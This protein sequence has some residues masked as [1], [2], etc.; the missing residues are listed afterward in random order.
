MGGNLDRTNVFDLT[1]EAMQ[2]PQIDFDLLSTDAEDRQHQTIERALAKVLEPIGV[3]FKFSIKRHHISPE[4]EEFDVAKT[5]LQ[6]PS[7]L[8]APLE[9]RLWVVCFSGKSLDCQVLAEPLTKALRKLNLEGFQDAVIQFSRSG[10]QTADW[11]LRIDLT[12]PTLI[13]QRWARWGDVQAITRLLNSR[14]NL[15]E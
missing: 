11:R 5:K 13:L 3:R 6:T 7:Q 15:T 12:P 9:H 4:T 1:A 10:A 2:Q 14:S 8:S